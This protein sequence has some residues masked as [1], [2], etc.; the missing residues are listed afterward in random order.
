ME[1]ESSKSLGLSKRHSYQKT[2]G[3][4]GEG[5]GGDKQEVEGGRESAGES[6]RIWVEYEVIR[7]GRGRGEGWIKSRSP[8]V[9][10]R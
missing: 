4:A 5:G 9:G 3:H 6:A 2:R 7:Q 8:C 10:G 1:L